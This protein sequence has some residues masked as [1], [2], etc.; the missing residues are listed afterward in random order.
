MWTTSTSLSLLTRYIVDSRDTRSGFIQTNP[1]ESYADDGRDDLGF[2]SWK[3]EP[4]EVDRQDPSKGG[5]FD[6]NFFLL[7]TS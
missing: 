5:S 7:E 2:V 1:T 4:A 6:F 3:Q